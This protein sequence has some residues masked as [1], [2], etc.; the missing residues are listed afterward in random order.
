M[1]K[2]NI[3]WINY[4]RAICM[5]AIYYIHSQEI[6]GYSVHGLSKNIFCSFM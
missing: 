5:V 1:E 2:K 3:E 6:F 4:V